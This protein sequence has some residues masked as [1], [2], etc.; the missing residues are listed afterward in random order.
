MSE[1]LETDIPP[2]R[3]F[4]NRNIV[5]KPQQTVLGLS[6]G[7]RIEWKK[8]DIRAGVP[9]GG[10]GTAGHAGRH[11]LRRGD[12]TGRH[13]LGPAPDRPARRD[14]GHADRAAGSRPGRPAK[15]P[16]RGP[17][18]DGRAAAGFLRPGRTGAASPDRGGHGPHR[19]GPV[20]LV[21]SYRRRDPARRAGWAWPACCRAEPARGSRCHPG[22]GGNGRQRGPGRRRRARDARHHR[23]AGPATAPCHPADTARRAAKRGA[24]GRLCRRCHA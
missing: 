8:K 13:R 3:W 7:I 12:D 9:G 14:R 1:S 11:R 24:S 10:T 2:T 17:T 4:G 18:A 15:R 20:D 22:P 6:D 21:R 16:P 5:L 19:P 23:P